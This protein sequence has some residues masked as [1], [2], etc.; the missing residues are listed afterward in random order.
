[1]TSPF[2][3]PAGYKPLIE[4]EF[5]WGYFEEGGGGRK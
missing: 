5:P 2:P 4:P 1:V 3:W